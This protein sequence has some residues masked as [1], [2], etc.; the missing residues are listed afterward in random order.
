M[1]GF[2][3]M[4]CCIVLKEI[5]DSLDHPT[6]AAMQ[7]CEYALGV[8]EILNTGH[9]EVQRESPGACEEVSLQDTEY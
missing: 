9:T 2:E 8:M 4:E 6:A 3:V 5:H 1:V 7:V